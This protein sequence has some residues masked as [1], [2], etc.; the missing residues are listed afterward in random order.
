MYTPWLYS[1]PALK[2][3]V[4]R[5][6]LTSAELASEL[7][8]YAA[9]TLTVSSPDFEGACDRRLHLAASSRAEAAENKLQAA[10]KE[11]QNLKELMAV[12]E[13]EHKAMKDTMNIARYAYTLSPC[14][15]IMELSPVHSGLSK[16]AE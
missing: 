16:Q 15:L 3:V 9:N 5:K 6:L 2:P 7:G 1:R 8:R 11:V 10:E 13:R 14:H 12:Q 4:G